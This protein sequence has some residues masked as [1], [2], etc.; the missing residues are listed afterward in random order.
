MEPP[1][2]LRGRGRPRAPLLDKRRITAAAAGLIRT[3]GL[4][5]LTMRALA[6]RLGVSAGALYNH[7]PSRSA[8]LA[9]VQ[10]DI[11][12]QLNVSGFGSLS[13]RDALAQWAWSYLRL[14][15]AQPAMVD[16]IVAVPVAHTVHTSQMYQRIVAAFREAGWYDRSVLPS[17]SAI[18]TFIFGAALDSAGPENVYEPAPS[19]HTVALSD[20]HSAFADLVRE[21]GARERDLVFQLGLDALLTGLLLR[22]GGSAGSP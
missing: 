13:L 7:A 12:E 11:S 2:P 14:L 19:E 17:L 15:R 1:Q 9:W 8:V 21:A 18:E 4:S 6:G 5:G 16:L 22:W 20:T 10:E 3:E